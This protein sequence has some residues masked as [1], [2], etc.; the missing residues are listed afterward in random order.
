MQSSVELP[1]LEGMRILVVDDTPDTLEA[2]GELLKLEGANVTL[3]T[4][5]R[6]AIEAAEQADFDLI[7]SDIAMPG[8]D[9][10][11][12]MA[13]LRKRD[14]TAKVMAVA[15]TGF[16]RP[17]DETRAREAGFDAH[18]AKPVE[19]AALLQIIHRLQRGGDRLSH[20]KGLR[21]I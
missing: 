11:E 21:V 5:G 8:M 13:E 7:L 20:D 12:L 19:L 14:R 16:G 15:V 18:V 3:A 1:A 17:N 2:F 4:S 10:Y 9:G 6:K